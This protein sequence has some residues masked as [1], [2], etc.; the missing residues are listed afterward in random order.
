[1]ST[2][3]RLLPSEAMRAENEGEVSRPVKHPSGRMMLLLL[4]QL[5]S[6]LSLELIRVRSASVANMKQ[7]EDVPLLEPTST[8]TR[9]SRDAD[10][11]RPCGPCALQLEGTHLGLNSILLRYHNTLY[12]C[13]ITRSVETGS[14]NILPSSTPWHVL[15]RAIVCILS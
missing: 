2:A 6:K 4:V 13:F 15:S 14:V 10:R 9:S 8:G 7:R 3:Q 12:V 11:A 1:M 5:L